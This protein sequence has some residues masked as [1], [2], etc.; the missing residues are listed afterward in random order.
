M[1]EER[2]WRVM[3]VVGGWWA[4]LEGVVGELQVCLEGV[5]ESGWCS[6]CVGGVHLSTHQ[7]NNS[8]TN[9]KGPLLFPLKENYVRRLHNLLFLEEYQQRSDTSRYDLSD[10]AV[11]FV[12][13]YSQ[14]EQLNIAPP[15]TSYLRLEVEEE[16]FEGRRSIK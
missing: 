2:T 15:G 10:V 8:G 13:S 12:S 14:G 5:V 3:G 16:L 4:W 9:P 7:Y 11:E 1:A 6:V